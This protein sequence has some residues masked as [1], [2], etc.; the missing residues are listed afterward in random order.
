[1][2]ENSSIGSLARQ[3]GAAV[4]KPNPDTAGFKSLLRLG[5]ETRIPIAV[6]AHFERSKVKQSPYHHVSQIASSTR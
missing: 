3:R 6:D 4:S 5:K 2:S 1:M